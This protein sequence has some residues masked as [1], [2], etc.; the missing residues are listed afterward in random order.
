VELDGEEGVGGEWSGVEDGDAVVPDDGES[1]CKD[2]FGP[3]G[4]DEAVGVVEGFLSG[5]QGA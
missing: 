3:V 4:V 5:A 2:A 1:A